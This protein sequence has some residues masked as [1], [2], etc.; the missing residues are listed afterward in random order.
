MEARHAID[1]PLHERNWAMKLFNYAP[2]QRSAF[3]QFVYA[4]GVPHVRAGKKRILFNEADVNAWLAQ[5]STSMR[6]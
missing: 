3:W 5:R 4:N 1:T 2:T 6:P